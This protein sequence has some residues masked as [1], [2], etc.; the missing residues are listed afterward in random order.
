MTKDTTTITAASAVPA[1]APTPVTVT[2]P[3]QFNPHRKGYVRPLIVEDEAL[4]DLLLKDDFLELQDRTGNPVWIPKSTADGLNTFDARD[5]AEM[6]AMWP[7]PFQHG[8]TFDHIR[9]AVNAYL[10]RAGQ[11]TRFKAEQIGDADAVL[12]SKLPGKRKLPASDIRALQELRRC[13]RSCDKESELLALF[14]EMAR[15]EAKRDG[16]QPLTYGRRGKRKLTDGGRYGW[17]QMIPGE[18]QLFNATKAQLRASYA[19]WCRM[20]GLRYISP[21]M[22]EMADGRIAVEAPLNAGEVPWSMRWSDGSPRPLTVIDDNKPLWPMD[23]DDLAELTRNIDEA[24]N[25]TH[26]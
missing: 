5:S 8:F 4:F 2:A 3:P 10:D 13:A 6:G 25:D 21:R 24:H 1:V 20:R 12:I 11:R 9:R 26:Q 18:A 7:H 23:A 14:D 17:G 16:K 19:S 22:I 15:L